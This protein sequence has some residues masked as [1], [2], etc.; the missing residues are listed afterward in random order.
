VSSSHKQRNVLSPTPRYWC[1]I[2]WDHW[3]REKVDHWLSVNYQMMCETKKKEK[4]RITYWM[5][6]LVFGYHMMRPPGKIMQIHSHPIIDKITWEGRFQGHSPPFGF[7][8]H[9]TWWKYPKGWILQCHLQTVCHGIRHKGLTGLHQ[10]WHLPTV[11]H[12]MI[13]FFSEQDCIEAY[14]LWWSDE[15][16]YSVTEI[17]EIIH[18]LWND[19]CWDS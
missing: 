9:Q 19:M 1:V 2:W 17:I 12:R 11:K 15:I 4:S 5:F 18:S 8:M 3:T 16:D 6:R 10:M 13:W 7:G 14:I